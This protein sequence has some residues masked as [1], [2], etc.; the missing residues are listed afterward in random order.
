MARKKSRL[1]R[2]WRWLKQGRALRYIRLA[3]MLSA[4][5]MANLD[6]QAQARYRT[7]ERF[8]DH[9]DPDRIFPY[10]WDEFRR[11]P[12]M[13]GCINCG[14]CLSRCPSIRGLTLD[15]NGERY[16]GPREVGTA[17][18][19]STPDLWATSDTLYYCTLC[20][21]CEAICPVGL[22]IPEIVEMV[23]RKLYH[24][25]VEV[26]LEDEDHAAEIPSAH[27]RLQENLEGEAGNI[28]GREMPDWTAWEKPQAEVVVFIGCAFTYWERESM[29]RTLRLLERLGVD[30]TTI[31]EQCCGGPSRVV[32]A[33]MVEAVARHTQEA[34]AAKGTRK[35]I[36]AC[37]RCYL[38]LAHDPAYADLEVVH[39]TTFLAE[40]AAA[41]G[42]R[43]PEGESPVVTYHDPCE[44][45]RC[46]GDYDAPRQV[47]EAAGLAL[48]EMPGCRELSN[49][50]GAGGGVRG[51][52]ARTSVAIARQ[53][54]EEAVATGA[55]VLLTECPSCLHNLRN[56]RRSRDA[57][58]VANLSEYLEGW[59]EER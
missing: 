13:E 47:I 30:F 42:E 57:M 44:I 11:L 21:A 5:G 52:Y 26:G 23:R 9:Y 55:Q 53:R 48:R 22:P 24:Q 18:S 7:L 59:L 12:E 20:G 41:L 54:Y 17:L 56:A 38:T 33:P 28:F 14:L 45:G 8:H 35:V 19:R 15:R 31:D 4:R 6:V 25:Q 16:A 50:C 3:R 27:L 46:V 51:A 2:F 49:C 40:R 58:D 32:G 39:T 36:T 34:I 43:V 10:T 37:P 1:A 29:E